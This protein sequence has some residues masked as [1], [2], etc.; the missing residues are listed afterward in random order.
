[1][2][3]SDG[4]H[5]RES[6]GKTP[7]GGRFVSYTV[8]YTSDDAPRPQRDTNTS[9]PEDDTTRF[10]ENAS[11]VWIVVAVGFV[12][13]IFPDRFGYLAVGPLGFAGQMVYRTFMALAF[14]LMVMELLRRWTPLRSANRRSQAIVAIVAGCLVLPALLGNFVRDLPYLSHPVEREYTQC[15]AIK[16]ASGGRYGNTSRLVCDQGARYEIGPGVMSDVD[17]KAGRPHRAVSYKVAYLPHTKVA[18]GSLVAR[19]LNDA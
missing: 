8:W 6:S 11:F 17:D 16:T 12:V 2:D 4:F 18:Q 7:D 9:I 5:V 10:D 14:A 13:F 1:M 3:N 19:G 15:M